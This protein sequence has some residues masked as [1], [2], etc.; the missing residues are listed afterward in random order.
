[1]GAYGKIG[2]SRAGGPAP[3]G[4]ASFAGMDWAA[5]AS[6]SGKPWLCQAASQAATDS[7]ALKAGHVPW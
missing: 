2:A 5:G 4:S 6:E 3:S 1:M 7:R